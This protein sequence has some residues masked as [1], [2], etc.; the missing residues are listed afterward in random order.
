M[1]CCDCCDAAVDGDGNDDDDDDDDHRHDDAVCV[2]TFV[3]LHNG[4]PASID[5]LF[6]VYLYS[7]S[8]LVLSE[9]G[10]RPLFATLRLELFIDRHN[11][12]NSIKCSSSSQKKTHTKKTEQVCTCGDF[13]IIIIIVLHVTK[14]RLRSSIVH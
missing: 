7:C 14:T 8:A 1:L 3:M 10:S 6:V 2:A 9:R 13:L 12:F 4:M 11:Q 5:F